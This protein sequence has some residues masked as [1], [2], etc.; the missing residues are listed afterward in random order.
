MRAR[1][2]LLA[3]RE[4]HPDRAASYRSQLAAEAVLHQALTAVAGE[5]RSGVWVGLWHVRLNI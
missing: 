2:Q 3:A 4:A 1:R 5:E